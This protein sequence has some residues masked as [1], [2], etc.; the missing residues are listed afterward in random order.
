MVEK[1]IGMTKGN[2]RKKEVNRRE[3]KEY[4]KEVNGREWKMKDVKKT[5]I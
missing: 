3:C 2:A 1:T 5:C 4:E